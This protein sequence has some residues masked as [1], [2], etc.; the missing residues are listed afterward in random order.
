[1]IAA[2]IAAVVSVIGVAQAYAGWTAV[3]RFA[4]RVERARSDQPLAASM[5]PAV[6]ILKPLHGDEPLL[7]EAL[8]STFQQDYPVF[9]IVFG[10]SAASD[11]ALLV[12]ERLQAR[13]PRVDVAIVVDPTLHGENRKVG[14]LINMLPAAKHDVLVIADSDVHV[15]SDWLR[16]LV[17]ALAEPRVGLVTAAYTGVA[18]HRPTLPDRAHI[19]RV[20]AVRDPA[21][22]PDLGWLANVIGSLG[23]GQI[24][25][26][27]LPGALIA[28]TLGRE[29]CLGATMMLRRETLERIGGFHALV[30]HLADD[31]VLGRLVQRL[32]LKVALAST[33][34][35]TTVPE[36]TFAA[37]WQH[38]LR[39]ARTVRTL[40]PLP[41]VA[42]VLQYPLAWAVLAVV[43][44]GGALW[45]LVWFALAWALRARAANGID[46]ALG[47][48]D[49][50]PPWLL[51]GREL[52]SV[53]V[54][55]A[56]YASRRVDWRGHTLR[57]EGFDAR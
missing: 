56:S 12:V 42:S 8:A 48:A 37:L 7:E 51:P 45:A 52:L 20:S 46:K 27:F 54:M 11:T 14:N 34:P 49:R 3:A 29:D 53:A 39:W 41:F 55:A 36:A 24:N 33:V 40:A 19:D 44:T 47:L 18:A 22:L 38:E 26:Y 21:P 6:T 32:G 43:L 15:M 9:Q 25:Q 13:L 57:A 5:L 23:A 17:D 16:R 10:V 28:R 30:N 35:A 1:M 50:T 4:N 2:G 31:N